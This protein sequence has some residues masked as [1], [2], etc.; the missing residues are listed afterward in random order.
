MIGSPYVW[1]GRTQKLAE[2]G[3]NAHQ[4]KSRLRAV[5]SCPVPGLVRSGDEDKEN[6]L[7]GTP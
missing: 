6:I 4:R 2:L 1:E 5:F 7:I 3:S